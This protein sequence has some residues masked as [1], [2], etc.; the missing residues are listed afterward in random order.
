MWRTVGEKARLTLALAATSLVMLVTPAA[1]APMPRA[2]V[3]HVILGAADL[4]RAI[5]AFEKLTGV[6]PIPKGPV[7]F[8]PA[9]EQSGPGA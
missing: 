5:D 2:H 8:E 7:F 4:D 3:D 6:R 1:G 9:I